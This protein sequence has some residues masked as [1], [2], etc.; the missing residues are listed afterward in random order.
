V[1]AH[2]VAAALPDTPCTPA[3]RTTF[4]ELTRNS[5]L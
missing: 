4:F 3:T 2:A 5:F 1:L